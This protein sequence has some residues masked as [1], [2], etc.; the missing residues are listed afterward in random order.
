MKLII[1]DYRSA[2]SVIEMK[3]FIHYIVVETKKNIT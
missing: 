3:I 2:T 1:G